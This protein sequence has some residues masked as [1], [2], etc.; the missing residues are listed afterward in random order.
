MQEILD[1]PRESVNSIFAACATAHPPAGDRNPRYN[2]KSR[3][4]D[5]AHAPKLAEPSHQ[6]RAADAN[7][8]RARYSL[9]LSS[10]AA[11]PIESWRRPNR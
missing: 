4:E 7:S 6:P 10:E 1:P 8:T 5:I 9:T 2:L 11:G 3:G